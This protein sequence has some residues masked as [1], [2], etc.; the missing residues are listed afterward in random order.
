M[1]LENGSN[2]LVLVLN[3]EGRDDIVVK[4]NSIE[5]TYGS[6]GLFDEYI[7]QDGVFTQ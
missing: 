2:P 3:V 1:A 7:Y 4:R 6:Q 5:I